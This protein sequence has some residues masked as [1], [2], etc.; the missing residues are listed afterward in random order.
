MAITFIGVST[1]Y[2]STASSTAYTIN[3]PA[4]SLTD[5]DLMIAVLAWTTGATN[6]DLTCTAPSGWTKQDEVFNAGDGYDSQLCVMTRS[7]VSGDPSTW[8]G[9]LSSTAAKVKV[10]GTTAYRGVQ[11]ILAKGTSS[12]ALGTSYSTATVNNSVANSWRFTTAA[13]ESG[14]LNYTMNTNETTSRALY[15]D[16]D[17]GVGNVQL[18]IADSNAAISTGNTS[19]TCSRS[20]NWDASTSWIGI[21]REAT[22]T[23]ATGTF[24]LSLGGVTMTADATATV[25]GTSAITLG[26]VTEAFDGFGTPPAVTGTF[27]LQLS[28]VSEAFVGNRPVTGV[29][30]MA[31]LPTINMSVET[32]IFG[33]RVIEIDADDRTI[34]VQSRGVDD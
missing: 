8:A 9:S 29:M 2:S 18:R 31:V 3:R 20:A 11:S 6:T 28:S 25:T 21:L 7:Y 14:S 17:G 33:V 15:D 4:G 12:A 10:S 30:D 22:G 5:G 27:A 24:N 32:R 26:N 34:V 23:A 16:L 1:K 13:Y 19:R